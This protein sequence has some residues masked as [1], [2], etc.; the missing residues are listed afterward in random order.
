MQESLPPSK[1]GM[2]RSTSCGRSTAFRRSGWT[3]S[4]TS[5]LNA[6]GRRSLP[7]ER[8]CQHGCVWRANHCSDRKGRNGLGA[9][10]GSVGAFAYQQPRKYASLLGGSSPRERQSHSGTFVS[11]RGGL[12]MEALVVAGVLI[13]IVG[14]APAILL[15]I[16][17]RAKKS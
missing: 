10:R 9:H 17:R 12:T 4:W 2:P 15:F 14:T 3:A 5:S 11:S 1:K 13:F 7:N 8:I 16:V 6:S